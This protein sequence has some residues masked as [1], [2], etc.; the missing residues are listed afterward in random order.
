MGDQ[1]LAKISV[2]S[3][4]DV[5]FTSVRKKQALRLKR[6]MKITGKQN[7]IIH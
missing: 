3:T 1:E 5:Q 2:K 4:R 6:S 7:I